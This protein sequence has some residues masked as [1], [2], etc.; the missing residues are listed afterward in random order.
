MFLPI[1]DEPNPRGLPLVTYLLIAANVVVFLFVALPLQ[2]SPI[3]PRDPATEPFLR[4]MLT[5]FAGVSLRDLLT[6]T[7]AYDVFTFA[8][9]YKP[10]APELGDLFAS[11]F[12]HAGWLH[13]FGNMLFLWIYGDNVEHRL[14]HV[15]YLFVYLGTGVV[16]TLFFALFA[17]DPL[18]P[19]IGASGAVSGVLG[20]YFLWFPHNRVRLLVVLFVF[21]DV[22]RVPARLVLL[23]YLLVDNLLPFLTGGG[24]GVAYG[25]HLGGFL[26]GLFVAM[27]F[28]RKPPPRREEKEV[29]VLDRDGQPIGTVPK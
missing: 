1:G 24:G 10:G 18:A 16:A 29:W 22:W 27:G 17:T 20:A 6:V 3:D 14:G 9:G 15:R 23:F 7:S 11:L 19:L 25:A 8:H 4:Y 13:L 21:V 12:L 2:S 28:N 26:A 5:R